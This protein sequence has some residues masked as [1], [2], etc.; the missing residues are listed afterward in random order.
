MCEL[1]CVD[2][3]KDVYVKNYT[4]AKTNISTVP[5]KSRVAYNLALN[6]KQWEDLIAGR[7]KTL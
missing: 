6:K 2:F 7:S 1:L 5:I 3:K 4:S